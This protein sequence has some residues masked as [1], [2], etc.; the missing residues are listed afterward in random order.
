MDSSVTIR[1][2]GMVMPSAE[3]AEPAQAAETAAPPQ[4]TDEI[5]LHEVCQ[6]SG[7]A[8]ALRA[9]GPKSAIDAND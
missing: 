8:L 6:D 7:E 1:F 9:P 4:P 3:G 2:P 5:L